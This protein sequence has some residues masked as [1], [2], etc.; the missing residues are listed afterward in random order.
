V[1][2]FQ[3]EG[4]NTDF[5]LV[6]VCVPKI[7]FTYFSNILVGININKNVRVSFPQYVRDTIFDHLYFSDFFKIILVGDFAVG[8]TSLLLKFTDN[9]FRES[10]LITTIGVDYVRFFTIFF[11][12]TLI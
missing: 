3:L 5:V 4:E 9:T 12:L 2:V 11:I 8:K 6:S 10:D 7:I 1:F